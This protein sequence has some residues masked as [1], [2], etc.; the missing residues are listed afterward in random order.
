MTVGHTLRSTPR[1]RVVALAAVATAALALTGC[2]SDATA[3]DD[4]GTQTTTIRI[5]PQPIADFAPIWLGM[6]QGYFT[7]EGLDIQLVEGGASSSAQ[8]PLLLS[9]NAD[10]AATTAAAAIQARSQN[11]PVTIVGG[12][13]NFAASD[14]VDQSGLVVAKDSS[15]SGFRDLEGKTV[16]ISGLKSV[17][18]AVISAAVEKSGGAADKISFIQAPMPNLGDLVSTGGADAAFLIDPFLSKATDSGLKILGRP[19]PLAAPGVPGTSLVASESFVDANPDSLAKF[20]TA[21]AKSVDYAN[22][23][24]GAVKAALSTQAKI[25]LEMLANSKN[26]QFVAVVEPGALGTEIELLVKYGVLTDSVE[27]DSLL[28]PAN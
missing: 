17:S 13:T 28:T 3:S 11:M 15:I 1:F 24:P 19:F 20:R 22:Q 10:M 18:E 25:P 14:G 2:S 23:N 4:G 26:P 27:A 8:I 16:A 7:D 12:L 6:E 21:L 9:G 5:A